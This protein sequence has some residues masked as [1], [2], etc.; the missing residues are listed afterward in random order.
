MHEKHKIYTKNPNSDSTIGV[1]H[2]IA[3]N[4][5]IKDKRPNTQ[6]NTPTIND[7]VDDTEPDEHKKSF[8]NP[9]LSGQIRYIGRN[10]D[11]P[12]NI[13]NSNKEGLYF[14]KI[15]NDIAIELDENILSPK[16][17]SSEPDYTIVIGMDRYGNFL[18]TINDDNIP[19][20]YIPDKCIDKSALCEID[21]SE[22]RNEFREKCK[23]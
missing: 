6:E 4:S 14:K 10:I 5:K 11:E 2:S 9:K 21:D 7:L 17:S 19:S 12:T 1:K 15:E 16:T 23:Q 3:E 13:D 18:N 8:S 22:E 20:P